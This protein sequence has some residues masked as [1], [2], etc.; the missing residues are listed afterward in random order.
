MIFGLGGSLV[1]FA[2][3]CYNELGGFDFVGV[4]VCR[5]PLTWTDPVNTV[6]ALTR[7]LLLSSSFITPLAAQNKIHTTLVHKIHRHTDKKY[8]K[9]TV[10]AKT[11]HTA[12]LTHT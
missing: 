10:P 7:H 1:N 9:V 11:R 12:S 4:K 3:F 2:K 6:L 5:L 8:Y